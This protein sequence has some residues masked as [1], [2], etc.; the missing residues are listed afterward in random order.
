MIGDK[1]SRASFLTK[2]EADLTTW[3]KAGVNLSGNLRDYSGV[4]P[5]MYTATYIS[6]WGF[7]NSTFDGFKDK[8]ERYPSGSTSWGNPFG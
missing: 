6:P 4:S 8:M 1:F 7:M 5:D 2:L 3:L